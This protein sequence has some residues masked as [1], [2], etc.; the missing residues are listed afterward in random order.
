[1]E[2]Y[3]MEWDYDVVESNDGLDVYD[4]ESGEWVCLLK[5]KTLAQYTY[6][7]GV[8]EDELREDIEFELN[9]EFEN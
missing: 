4:K 9:Y 8:D 5:W 3:S 7:D 6:D 1:M 2:K